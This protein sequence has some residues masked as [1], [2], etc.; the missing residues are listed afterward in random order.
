LVRA[1]PSVWVAGEIQRVRRSRNGHLYFELVEKGKADQIIGK[2]EGVV[3]RR[4]LERIERSLREFEQSLVDGIE[5]RCRCEVDFY[6][7]F[8]R[9]QLVVR[10]VDPVF[11]L[12]Q[13]SRRRRETLRALTEAGLTERNRSL[14]M[15]AVP[16]RIA[17]V[18]SEGSA[19]YRDF[20]AALAASG[21]GFRVF[22]VHTAVQ[23]ITA[24]REIVAA[25]GSAREIEVDCIALVRG[26]GARSDLAAFDSRRV[27]EAVAR[28]AVPVITGLGHEIDESVTDLVAHT[29]AITPTQAAEKLV[30]LVRRSDERVEVAGRAVV[31]LSRATLDHARVRLSGFE[32][33]LRVAGFRLQSEQRRLTT[34]AELLRRAAQSRVR[35]GFETLYRLEARF[36]LAT[37]RT[38][39]VAERVL[40]ERWSRLSEEVFRR[41][42][43]A[44]VELSSLS[45]LSVQLAPDRILARGFSITREVRGRVLR[46]PGQVSRGSRIETQL[47]GGLL[48]SVVGE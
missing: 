38:L 39:A 45:R 18:T 15:P 26:G 28:S 27:A 29:R 30:Q 32:R 10:D 44:E 33:D 9:L 47:A 12:G 4:D 37:P 46:D 7:P 42:K 2:L 17:L 21:Y 36:V 19:A 20:V 40:E 48:V 1:L 3:W 31:A 22:L 25:L 14:E 5:T 41:L 34:V 8:G 11:T 43:K 16:M 6:P 13:L 23:G 35:E 24:E